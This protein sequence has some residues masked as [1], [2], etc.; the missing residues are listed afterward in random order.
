VHPDP[1]IAETLPRMYRRVLD[2][3][4]QLERLGARGEAARFRRTAIAVYS[5][6]WNAK[7][8]RQLEEVLARAEVA[9]ADHERRAALRVA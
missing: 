5:R 2:A 6:A 8:H 1:T 4:G 3:V 9:A 7:S